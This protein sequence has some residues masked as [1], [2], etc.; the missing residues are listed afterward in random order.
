M[1]SVTNLATFDSTFIGLAL[2]GFFG[3]E[4][5]KNSSVGGKASNFNQVSHDALDPEILAFLKGMARLNYL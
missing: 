5:L 3:V 2:D 4:V 1:K